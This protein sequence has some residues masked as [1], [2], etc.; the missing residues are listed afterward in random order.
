MWSIDNRTPYKVER[1]WGRDRD[2]VHEWIVAVKATYDIRPDGSV[3]LAD[4]Q[5]DALLAPEY[6][7]KPGL[8]S[9]RYDADVVGAKP[10]TDIIVVGHAYA[11]NQ[12]PSS[13]FMIELAVGPVR[14][15]LRVRGDRSRDGGLLPGTATSAEPLV[16]VPLAYERAYGGYDQADAESR[17]HRLDPRNPIGVGLAPLPPRLPNFEYPGRDVETAGPAGFGAID[18]HWSPRLEAQGTYDD[19]WKQQR[20]PLL[21]IDWSPR[22]RQCAPLD[23]LPSAPLHG[24]EGVELV[25]LTPGGRLSF[26]L[27]RAALRF[28]TRIDGRVEEHGAQLSTVIIEADHPRVVLV[29][30]SS[31]A[32]RTNGDYLDSTIVREKARPW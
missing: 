22:S 16:R 15:T 19:A 25:N 31:L 2:G 24:G 14:K 26:A 5:L 11:P 28:S 1:A 6:S 4:E 32:V 9:L 12:R 10:T 17:R 30:Q 8:S 21:P 13:D 27:P 7:G 23:Q 18:S 3:A 29:W 20:F